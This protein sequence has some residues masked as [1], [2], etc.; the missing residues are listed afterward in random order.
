MSRFL[1]TLSAWIFATFIVFGGISLFCGLVSL[2]FG[3]W[4]FLVLIRSSKINYKSLAPRK[5]EDGTEPSP[6]GD[7]TWN[8][9]VEQV[10]KKYQA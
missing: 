8:Q 2:P 7:L 1:I 9:W 6:F 4:T 10:R 3:L 5:N